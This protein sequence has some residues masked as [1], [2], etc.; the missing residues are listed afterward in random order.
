VNIVQA[1]ALGITVAWSTHVC[2]DDV[3]TVPPPAEVPKE[4]AAEVAQQ[5][6]VIID[7]RRPGSPKRRRPVHQGDTAP[8]P[9]PRRR[10]L[11]VG[12]VVQVVR[13]VTAGIDTSII[14]GFRSSWSF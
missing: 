9:Q 5:A 14:W 3:A 7:A 10:L 13:D 8:P 4:A 6:D 11:V 1:A 2:A 12:P